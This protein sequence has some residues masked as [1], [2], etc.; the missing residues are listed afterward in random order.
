MPVC[1]TSGK[2]G[3]ETGWLYRL[4]QRPKPDAAHL[5]RGRITRE[6]VKKVYQHVSSLKDIAFLAQRVALAKGF[7]VRMGGERWDGSNAL[8]IP[9]RSDPCTTSAG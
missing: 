1:I 8:P 7:D 9:I 4:G 5:R 2:G 6:A 3:F